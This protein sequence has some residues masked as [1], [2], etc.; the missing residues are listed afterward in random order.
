[1]IHFEFADHITGA[2]PFEHPPKV[3]GVFHSDDGESVGTGRDIGRCSNSQVVGRESG[4]CHSRQ[5]AQRQEQEST[6]HPNL[7]TKSH[8]KKEVRSHYSGL[9]FIR[10]VFGVS[11]WLQI[12]PHSV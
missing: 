6:P 3:F 9:L 11:F 2:I 7:S 4:S 12:W 1:M 10:A 5:Q 8:R